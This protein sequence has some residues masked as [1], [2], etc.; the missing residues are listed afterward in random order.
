MAHEN[1]RSKAAFVNRKS[2]AVLKRESVGFAAEHHVATQ[3]FEE[4]FPEHAKAIVQKAAWNANGLHVAIRRRKQQVKAFQKDLPSR[5]ASLQVV[6]YRRC[7]SMASKL[8][9]KSEKAPCFA[10]NLGGVEVRDLQTMRSLRA[11]NFVSRGA[12]AQGACGAVTL[13]FAATRSC[14]FTAFVAAAYTK[15]YICE[16]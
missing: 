8:S 13:S 6:H 16:E 11:H 4:C 15:R 2:I 9:T 14:A 3:F 10:R 7:T 1:F 12:I 5:I